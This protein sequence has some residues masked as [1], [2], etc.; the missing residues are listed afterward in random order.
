MPIPESSSHLHGTVIIS[1]MC[2]HDPKLRINFTIIIPNE[3]RRLDSELIPSLQMQGVSF[4][5]PAS[6][7]LGKANCSF[8]YHSR[9]AHHFV[10]YLEHI[11]TALAIVVS[12]SH[13]ANEFMSR[14]NVAHHVRVVLLQCH[15]N[16]ISNECSCRRITGIRL[17]HVVVLGGPLCDCGASARWK[18]ESS[19]F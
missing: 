7:N 4:N 18:L 3:F 16:L 2:T 5:R 8:Q 17:L 13:S 10:W 19:W 12:S 9:Y 14:L 11:Y 1:L 15:D 6:H